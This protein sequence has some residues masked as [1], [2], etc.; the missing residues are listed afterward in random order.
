MRR[1]SITSDASSFSVISRISRANSFDSVKSFDSQ[2]SLDSKNNV[3]LAPRSAASTDSHNTVAQQKPAAGPGSAGCEEMTQ[4]VGK[5]SLSG[6]TDKKGSNP[7]WDQFIGFKHSPTAPFKSEF[8]RLAQTK[9]WGDS[10]KQRQFVTLLSSEV[11]FF[12]HA[13]EDKLYH[14]QDLC[15]DLDL[16]AMSNTVTQYKKVSFS[17]D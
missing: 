14:C 2:I 1:L 3:Q 11:A 6:S 16:G 13:D 15:R 12:W 10:E 9:G 17:R 4:M 8:E 5:L 7:A